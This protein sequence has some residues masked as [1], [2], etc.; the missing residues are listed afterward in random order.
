MYDPAILDGLKRAAEY[1]AFR[2]AQVSSVSVPL[3][4][5]GL[6]IFV[7]YVGHLVAEMFRS[8]GQGWG[9]LGRFDIGAMRE[10]ARSRRE[11]SAKLAKQ[12]KCWV[13]VDRFVHKR[14]SGVPYGELHNLRLALRREIRDALDLLLTPTLPITTPRL[15]EPTA[16]F[17]EVSVRTVDRLPY[18]TSPLNLSGNPAFSIP[19][20]TDSDGLPTAVQ[21]VGS[22]FDEYTACRAA[23]A[24][25]K[26]EEM[27][28]A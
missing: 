6:A 18:N 17:S 5:D 7:P 10:F 2:G 27:G 4:R 24:L 15:A 28:A 14:E 20:G 19:S 16:V 26:C 21:I 3:W 1:L 9:H 23:F 25:E 12:V 22:H 8:E 11:E 13:I